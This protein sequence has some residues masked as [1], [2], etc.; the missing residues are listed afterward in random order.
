MPWFRSPRHRSEGRAVSDLR[1][2]LPG[3]GFASGDR[4]LFRRTAGDL[5]LTAREFGAVVMVLAALAL[6]GT[7][8]RTLSQR[9]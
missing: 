9:R 6:I 2:C 8:R 1:G 5:F 3:D 4:R 7:L